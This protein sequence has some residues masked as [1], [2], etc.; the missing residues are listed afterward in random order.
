MG[1]GKGG[2]G[3]ILLGIWCSVHVSKLILLFIYPVQVHVTIY[4]QLVMYLF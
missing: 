1:V 4:S 3:G 2:F